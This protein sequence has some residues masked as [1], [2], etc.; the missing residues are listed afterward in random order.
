L[1][2]LNLPQL[3]RAC[4]GGGEEEMRRR[5]ERDGTCSILGLDDG[6]PVAQL[7]VRAYQPGYRA[8]RGLHSGEFWAD[9]KG[10]EAEIA[11]PERTALLGCWHVGRVR[12][13][14]GREREAEQYRGRGVG[15]A[16]ARG[17]ID[18]LKRFETRFDALAVKA[19]ASEDRSY[20][21]YVGVLSR[22]MLESVGF[23]CMASYE[24]PYFA[25]EPDALPA[26]IQ[27][28]NPARFHL[29]LFGK[30]Q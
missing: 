27:V 19:G 8:P 6:R 4:W 16:L 11:L 24:D 10:I 23:R 1:S 15:I 2:L 26:E 20:L 7:Y 21:G 5:I 25:E 14:D 12:D 22:A 18:W 28:D 29:M 9:L 17:A 30:G 3:E 13:R